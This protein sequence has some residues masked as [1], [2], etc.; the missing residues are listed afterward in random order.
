[1]VRSIG[2]G[3]V[4]VVAYAVIR[5]TS[6]G[7]IETVL[8]VAA[9]VGI[10]AVAA[11]G[12]GERPFITAAVVSFVTMK[13]IEYFALFTGPNWARPE[14]L[15]PPVPMLLLMLPFTVIFA[16]LTGAVA[17]GFRKLQIR[18]RTAR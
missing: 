8:L 17:L 18:P 13:C 10:G 5:Q 4:L 6:P 1:M 11:Y 7:W 3:F 15:L 9:V 14:V 12:N 2:L 16:A